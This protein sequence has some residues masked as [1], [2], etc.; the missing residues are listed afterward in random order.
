MLRI[1][2]SQPDFINRRPQ[3][4]QTS[5]ARVKSLPITVADQAEFPAITLQ[6]LVRVVLTQRQPILS[7]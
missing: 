1:G 5:L 3:F 2:P 6:P 4:R 7:A